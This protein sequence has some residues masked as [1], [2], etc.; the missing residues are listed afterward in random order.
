MSLYYRGYTKIMDWKRV[1]T[2]DLF[3]DFVLGEIKEIEHVLQLT[4]PRNPNMDLVKVC[5]AHVVR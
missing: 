3:M 2:L 1:A 5:Q 4:D